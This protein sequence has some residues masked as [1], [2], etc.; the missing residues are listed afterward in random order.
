MDN[1]PQQPLSTKN[2]REQYRGTQR[3]ITAINQKHQSRERGQGI[4]KYR[5]MD[6]INEIINVHKRETKKTQ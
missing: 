1:I 6:L 5:G 4:I 2:S 3:T